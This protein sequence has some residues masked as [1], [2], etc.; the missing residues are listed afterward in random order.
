[1]NSDFPIETD[2]NFPALHAPT[3]CECDGKLLVACYAG[4]R[5]GSRDSVVLGTKYDRDAGVWSQ[6]DIWV[7]VRNKAP[8]NPRL[9]IGPDPDE[10]CL[11][12]GVN[13]GR[14]CSGDT[15][16]FFK[17]TNDC[18]KSWTDLELLYEKKGLLGRTKPYRKRERWILPLEEEE[19]WT[20]VF[21][22]SKDGGGNWEPVEP[23]DTDRETHLIQPTI[24]ELDNGELLA[25]LRSQEGFIYET[26][27]F[28]LGESWTKPETTELPNNN[29]GID[30]I[31]LNS[32]E[33]LI[34]YNPTGNREGENKLSEKWP[35]R[36][37]ADFKK[38]GPRTPLRLSFSRDGGETWI[39]CMDVETGDGEYSYPS[40]IQGGNG[41]I[42]LVYTYDRKAIKHISLTEKELF[43]HA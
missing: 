6:Q 10:V 41:R 30:M 5:E 27:S 16:L 37:P 21:L 9:F 35:E 15:Y 32:G 33:L 7:N 43:S 17:R 19:S 39:S 11:L 26:R 22:L 34:A 13:Y 36:M 18:G 40:L 24:V 2:K 14:W 12:V 8:A 28:D 31:R 23:E 29:S 4:Q 20:P 38:W 3:I 25:Y 1:M 42:H